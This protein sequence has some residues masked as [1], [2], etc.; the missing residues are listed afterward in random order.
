[1]AKRIGAVDQMNGQ[2]LSVDCLEGLS[3]EESA[4]KIAEHFS[5]NSNEYL[6]VNSNQL[7]SYLPAQKP[8]TVSE[9]EVF[10]RLK[11]K[12]NQHYLLIYLMN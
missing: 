8:P 7:P 11:R 9:M 2:E 3:N 5:S 4:Q 6:P 12:Q 10:E 1:M